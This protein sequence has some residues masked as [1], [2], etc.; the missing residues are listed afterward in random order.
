MCPFVGAV[1][2]LSSQREA[3]RESSDRPSELHHSLVQT[4]THQAHTP[5]L[6]HTHKHMTDRA[7]YKN[8]DQQMTIEKWSR[9]LDFALA[10]AHHFIWKINRRKPIIITRNMSLCTTRRDSDISQE[11]KRNIP[12][13][14][15][16]LFC[17]TFSRLHCILRPIFYFFAVLFFYF[18]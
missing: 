11:L 5:Q 15:S 4:L 1:T 12:L 2:L 7:G 13:I 14:F 17:I 18:W 6:T 16:C 8:T 3:H 9:S 10:F